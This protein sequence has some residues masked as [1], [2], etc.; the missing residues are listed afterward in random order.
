MPASQVRNLYENDTPT[1]FTKSIT[2]NTSNGYAK[3]KDN[4]YPLEIDASG[5]TNC[6]GLASSSGS[7]YVSA[8]AGRPFALAS[9]FK[10][11]AHSSQG[12]VLSQTSGADTNNNYR[13]SLEVTNDEELLFWFGSGQDYYKWT[14]K[15]TLDSSKWY[16]FY[17]DYDGCSRS[18][19]NSEKQKNF[20]RFRVWQVDLSTGTATQLTTYNQ[21]D[22]SY[23]T[24]D[25]SNS[26]GNPVQGQFYVGSRYENNDE[27]QGQIAAVVVTTLKTNAE[28]LPAATEIG[29]LVSNPLQWLTDYKVGQSFRRPGQTVNRANFSLNDALGAGST[30]V[31]LMG[32]GTND[33]CNSTNCK[34]RNQVYSGSA[35]WDLET[36]GINSTFQNNV[37][38]VSAP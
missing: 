15:F 3:Q 12:T 25:Q 11:G 24:W 34:F 26:A 16:G 7:S 19:G 36:T 2:F 33:Q 14:S 23:G 32:G 30:K 13:I 10:A 8:S 17:V 21:N 31:W 18:Y 4:K 5:P 20:N 27:F 37:N 1:P 38:N 9:V 28:S 29:L 22:N 35:D 6:R